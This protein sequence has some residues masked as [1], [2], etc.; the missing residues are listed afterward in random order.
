[1]NLTPEQ[2]KQ[3]A[4]W[5]NRKVYKTS[6]NGM[7]GLFTLDDTHRE[8]DYTPDTNDAQAFELLRKLFEK[9]VE[10]DDPGY[11]SEWMLKIWRTK[12]RGQTLK[13]AICHAVLSLLENR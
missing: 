2:R 11:K 1:M 8:V 9:M 6:L 7:Q 10:G 13:L 3:I 4:E 5:A 12:I